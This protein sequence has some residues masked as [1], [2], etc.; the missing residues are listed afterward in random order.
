M[1]ESRN[2][3]LRDR[4]RII[5]SDPARAG[6]SS[7]MLRP[8]ASHA[9][10]TSVAAHQDARAV[11]SPSRCSRLRPA[12]AATSGRSTSAPA[13]ARSHLPC[14]A[15]ARGRGRRPGARAA[16]ART[17]ARPPERPVRR[18]RRDE[19]AVRRRLVRPRRNAPTLH[20]VATA[21]A[22]DRRARPRTRARAA[23]ARDRPAGARRSDRARRVPRVRDRPRSSHTRLLPDVDLRELFAANGLALVRARPEDERRDLEPYLDLAG[24][25]GE[26][27]TRAEE[28]AATDARVLAASAGWYLLVRG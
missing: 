24:S 9:R 4:L 20:H 22:R 6:A 1:R 5:S 12:R 2:D 13:P 15:R 27:R 21:G 16:R 7:P 26:G 28:L 11:G 3:R 25:A 14:A 19:P 8:T 18:G 17:R 10:Q 23:R